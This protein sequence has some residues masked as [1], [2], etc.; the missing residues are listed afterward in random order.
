MNADAEVLRAFVTAKDEA[1]TNRQ[2]PAGMVRLSVSHSVL[3]SIVSK[4]TVYDK[5]MSI[6]TL[7]DK[8]ER[9]YGTPVQFMTLQ[10]YDAP[11]KGGQLLGNLTDESK[12]LGY[13]SPLDNMRLHVVDRDPNHTVA[14]LQ[15][16]SQV[17]KYEM[18]EKDY[19]ARD[20]TVRKLKQKEKEKKEAAGGGT[21]CGS[22]SCGSPG[23]CGGASEEVV[24]PDHMHVGDRCEIMSGDGSL[25]RRGTVMYVGGLHFAKGC[26]VGVRFDEPVGKND[27]SAKGQKYF[28]CPMNY[29]SFTKPDKVTVGDFPEL[30]LFDDDEEL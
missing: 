24:I 11:S 10:L 23:T 2:S 18:S 29:G 7:K 1:D 14:L 13:Y 8:L 30:D 22:V 17:E 4:F 21:G 6:G 25:G 15:D 26:W 9:T 28:D 20:N 3:T 19:N 5:S 12:L 27:G 16:V